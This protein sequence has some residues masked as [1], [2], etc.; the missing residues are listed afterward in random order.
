MGDGEDY[1]GSDE[2]REEDSQSG[3]A[4]DFTDITEVRNT[5]LTLLR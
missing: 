3:A 1:D 2:E 4:E 5:S